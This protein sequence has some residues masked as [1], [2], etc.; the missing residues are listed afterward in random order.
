[1]R[2]DGFSLI[3]CLAGMAISLF[4]VCSSLEFLG[5]SQKLFFELKDKAENSQSALAALDKIRIDLLHAGEGLVRPASQGVIEIISAGDGELSIVKEQ[6]SYGLARDIPSESP[7]VSLSAITDL[8]PGR[9][10]CLWD[11][12]KGE[13]RE[14]VAVDRENA[15]VIVDPPLE[16]PYKK[17]NAVLSLLET[18]R[19]FLDVN[20]ATL[21]RQVNLSSAQPLLE[22]VAS[23]VF[24]YDKTANT[25]TVRFQ[26]STERE[27]FYEISVFSKNTALAASKG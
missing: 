4:I 23:I 15:A 11:A 26:T 2:R 8:K 24:G 20:T 7:A 9:K 10:I 6:R 1:M 25:V 14:I 5:I 13:V 18:T 17:E 19:L 21:R 3:E 12:G 22:N 16:S 27:R